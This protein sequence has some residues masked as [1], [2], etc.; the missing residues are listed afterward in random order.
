MRAFN[1]VRPLAWAAL[2]AGL[3]TA[4]DASSTTATPTATPTPGIFEVDLLFPRNT[5]YTPQ[6]LMPIVWALQ[7]PTLAAP[8]AATILWIMWE[9][10]NQSSPGSIGDGGLELYTQD[11]LSSSNP[12]M[13]TRF[14]NVA[15]VPD[16]VWTLSWSL[17]VYN[18]SQL[19][20]GFVDNENK[21]IM[22]SNT[23]VFTTSSSGQAPDLVAATSAD[24]CGSAEAFAFDVASFG[25]ACGFPGAVL[26]PK[27]T[28]TTNP[29]AAAIN[30]SVASSISAAATAWGCAPQQHPLNPNVSCPPLH[31]SGDPGSK[32]R[33]AAAST[34]LTLLAT[35]TALIYLG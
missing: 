25:T 26:A 6:E 28:P 4:G 7:N 8:L 31:F 20:P 21:T 35:L 12:L 13:A 23:V 17:D 11:D 15:S 1:H 10:D 3:M 24:V 33:M 34:L 19:F 29:C 30:A 14:V 27:P 5:T 18:C 9:G 32:S 16:G 2:M 22:Q